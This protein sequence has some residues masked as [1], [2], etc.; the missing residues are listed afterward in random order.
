MTLLWG[1]R[2]AED[3]YAL[4]TLKAGLLSAP[5]LQVW[6]AAESG[7]TALTQGE[8]L[9]VTRGTVADALNGTPTLIAG[10]DIYAAGPSMMLRQLVHS[11]NAQGV[12]G[13]RLHI[14]QFGT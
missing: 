1:V 3:F 8:R 9:T 6:L 2:R 14:D 11:L 10:R 4:D 13:D 12:T 5:K 7:D